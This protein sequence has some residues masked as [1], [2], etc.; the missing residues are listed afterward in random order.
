[1]GGAQVSV[2]FPDTLS[3]P[4]TTHE[5]YLLPITPDYKVTAGPQ[6]ALIGRPRLSVDSARVYMMSNALPD[7]FEA[8][9]TEPIRILGLDE[10]AHRRVRLIGPAGSRVI[11]DSADITFEVEPLIFKSRKVVIEPVNVPEG[12]KLITFPAQADV[13]YMVPMSQYR[14]GEA[15]FRVVADYR[16]ISRSGKVKLTVKN[17][18]ER[19]QNVH[20]SADSAEYIIE[21]H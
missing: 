19:F 9:T 11:P 21:R 16:T 2:V 20:L 14:Q 7:R 6:S 15:H 10:T 4:F 1:M 13:F 12:I 18:P 17:V 5:G 8:I 3:I